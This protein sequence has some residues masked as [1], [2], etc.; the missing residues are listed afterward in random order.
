MASH[1]TV[2]YGDHLRLGARIV[3]FHGWDLPVQYESILAE[4][5]HCRQAACVFDT[6]HMGQILIRSR[7]DD[8][9][10]MTTQDAA[11][12]PIG[13]GKYGFLLNDQGGILDD[14]ILMRLGDEEFLLVV[15][16]GPA[17]G[18]F[19]WVRGHLPPS[20]EATLQS[21]AGWGKIDLQGPASADVLAPLAEVPLRSLRYFSV[22]RTRVCDLSCVVS[23][24]GYT[25]ELGYEIF[26]PADAILAVFRRLVADP[27][28]RPAGLGARDSLRLEASLPLYGDDIDASTSPIEAGLGGFVDLARDFSG[29]AALRAAAASGPKR[30]LVA[31]AARGRQRAWRGDVIASADGRTGVVTSAAFAPS[32]GVAIGMGYVPPDLASPGAELI[33]KTRRGDLP[34]TV[35]EKPLYKKGTCRVR[36]EL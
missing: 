33:V 32:L 15:N 34:V 21:A 5:T 22:T 2:L 4:H 6:S 1:R 10:R 20:A 23:R 16:A 31:F 29:A 35:A 25:G 9:A 13:R 19:D 28:V 30:L 24:T 12:L 18:D 36:L 3:D 17:A 8:L 26:A 7:P 11:A 27:R 14:T